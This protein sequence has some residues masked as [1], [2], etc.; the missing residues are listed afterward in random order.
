MDRF[1]F[2]YGT[3]PG[4]VEKGEERFAVEWDHGDDSV[5]YDVLGFSRP[6]HPMAWPGYPLARSLQRRFA[7]DSKGEIVRATAP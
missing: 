5:H 3:L 1:G 7:R 4:H 6:K 2:A